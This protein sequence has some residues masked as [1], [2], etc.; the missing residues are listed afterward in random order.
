MI[1]KGLR[2]EHRVLEIQDSA[3]LM[4]KI[5]KFYILMGKVKVLVCT[6]QG[7]HVDGDEWLSSGPESNSYPVS[8]RRDVSRF[9]HFEVD[10]I[11]CPLRELNNV[12]RSLVSKLTVFCRLPL[13]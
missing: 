9:G 12:A 10:K 3:L 2:L 11:S 4:S 13:D 7:R 5:M 8:M 1:T 6:R